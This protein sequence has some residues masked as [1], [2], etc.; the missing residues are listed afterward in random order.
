MNPSLW[1]SHQG[2]RSQV[3]QPL[4]SEHEISVL[5]DKGVI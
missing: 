5:K 3:F 1:E 4:V 2:N